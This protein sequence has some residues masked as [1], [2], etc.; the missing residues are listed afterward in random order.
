[1]NWFA[2]LTVK[3]KLTGGFLIVAIIA[4]IIGVVGL[5]SLKR[6]DEMAAQMYEREII[7]LRQAADARG[8]VI[9]IEGALR[10]AVAASQQD[11]QLH[12]DRLQQRFSV[13]YSSLERLEALFVTEGGL[14]AVAQ[15]KASVQTYE[16]AA[17]KV[18]SMLS[19]GNAESAQA[20]FASEVG[21]LADN[22][23]D[24]MQRLV[25]EKQD[26]SRVL[27]E[28]IEQVYASTNLI[29]IV[30]TLAGVVIAILLG[31]LLTRSLTRQLGGEPAAAA[32][33]ANAIARGDL[34]GHIDTS[35]AVDG[36]VVHAMSVMQNALSRIVSS[37]RASSDSIATGSGQISYGNADLSQRTEEQAANLTETA[38]AMEELS[39]TVKSNADVAQ[40]AAHL[41]EAASGAA[42][43]GGEVV[44]EVVQT[45]DEINTSSK[46]IVDIIAVIDSIAFQTNILAL[47]AAVEAARAGEQGR[48]FAVVA[49]EVRSLA[50]KSAA[51]AK[52]IKQL[53]DESVSRA[54]AGSQ[55][56]DAAG[57]AMTGIVTQVQR[58]TDLISEIS[59]ATKEQTTG[60]AQVNDAVLQL[61]DVTQ[62]NA[63][64]V[65][66]SAAA[67]SS[68][69]E[70]AKGLVEA[71]GIFKLVQD[72]VRLKQ[73]S[74][75]ETK[76]GTV[77]P[78][79]ARPLASAQVKTQV[80]A[81]APAQLA[82]APQ[83]QAPAPSRQALTMGKPAPVREEEWEEF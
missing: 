14:A 33:A 69:N 17:K 59:A 75:R 19:G 40:Q 28:R 72:E 34:T 79:L 56:V 46:K 21:P 74:A 61:S 44:G 53:I 65:E 39:S 51:A 2:N 15:A 64:L 10:G 43:K 50:Q 27:D 32:R 52:D 48:G 20:L 25:E 11:R 8:N 29:L 5:T 66:Q 31:L 12:I 35:R 30:L 62:Q 60:I 47:N 73:Q 67:S 16:S 45:M 55:M 83:Q 1:M 63:A 58:V 54:Q 77:S 6:V 42:V 36:S 49:S 68:L 81:A 78:A 37:V 80:K 82:A 57:E 18:V 22:T 24:I 3:A 76:V 13:A 26:N 9:G 7:G 4:A 70:Q 71:V 38:A 23:Q 41:A